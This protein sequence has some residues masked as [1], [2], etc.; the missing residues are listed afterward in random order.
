MISRMIAAHL[1]HGS[2]LGTDPSHETIA[3]AS[4]HFGAP[5][6]WSN[7]RGCCRRARGRLLSGMSWIVTVG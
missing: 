7:E 4:S 3:F 2:A 5:A 6:R 1:L